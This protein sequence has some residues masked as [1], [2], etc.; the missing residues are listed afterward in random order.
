MAHQAGTVV[1]K[2][3]QYRFHPL[4]VLG[5]QFPGAVMKVRVNQAQDMGCLKRPLLARFKVL[6]GGDDAGTLCVAGDLP[7]DE[8][9]SLTI[10]PNRPIGRNITQ[11]LLRCYDEQVIVMQLVRPTR[12]MLMQF[13]DDALHGSGKSTA[14]P[15][16]APEF[17]LERLDR[18]IPVS[19]GFVIPLLNGAKR[20]V[21]WPSA[22]RM[23][24]LPLGQGFQF[25]REVPTWR[26]RCQQLPDD[27]EAETPPDFLPAA[28]R[29]RFHV[30]RIPSVA[31][32]AAFRSRPK[33]YKTRSAGG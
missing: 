3:D 16:I 10:P 27:G 30:V 1:Q 21:E 33:D 8:T 24:P 25:I 2:S 26:R 17:S 18:I 11:R 31:L 22:Y 9:V 4:P 7:A 14:S 23:L 6:K 32:G 13:L 20:H 15:D 19:P 5:E 28:T 29:C 12:M